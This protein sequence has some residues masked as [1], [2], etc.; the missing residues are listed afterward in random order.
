MHEASWAAHVSGRTRA[1][2][3]G[4]AA[5]GARPSSTAGFTAREGADGMW[6][7]VAGCVQGRR[8][9]R[10]ARRDLD[11]GPARAAHPPRHGAL[12]SAPRALLAPPSRR[13][14]PVPLAP[15]PSSR[16]P[17]APRRRA[18]LPVPE[19]SCAIRPLASS[20]GSAMPTTGAR[21]FRTA[22]PGDPARYPRRPAQASRPLPITGRTHPPGR[23]AGQQEDVWTDQG[24]GRRR[25]GR[26]AQDRHRRALRGPRYRGRRHCANGRWPW[27]S[28]SSSS[29]T[30]SPWTSRCRRWTASRRCARSAQRTAAAAADH[31]VQHADRARRHR[32]PRR[33]V[34]RRQRLRH[35]AGQRRQRRAVDGE[36]PRAAHPQDQGAHRPRRRSAGPDR[37]AAPRRPVAVRPRRPRAARR[38]GRPPSWSSAPRPAARR[39]W[40][41]CSRRCRPT[42]PVPVLLVQHMPPVFTRQF[43]Q[44]LDRL[45]ALRVVEAADGDPAAARHRAHRPRRPPPGRRPPA[46]RPGRPALNQAP[47][48]NFCRPAVDVL[49]RSAVAAYGGAV[50]GVV[51]TGMGSDGRA[52]PARSAPP[53]ARVSRRTRPP[54]WSG[55][56]PARS[57]RPG[58]ADEVLPLDRVAEAILRLLAAGD[59]R[60]VAAPRPRGGA[61]MTLTATELRL[62]AP[63]GAPRERDRAGSPARSTSSRRG[64][65]RS[66]G[67]CGLSGRQRVRRPGAQPARPGDH[68]ADRR[69]ADH[70][71]DLVVPRRRPVH[72]AH[73]DRAARSWSRPGRPDEQ[74]QIWSAACSS[75]QEPYSSRCCST[76]ALPGAATRVVDH[77]DRPVPRDGRAHPGRPVQPARGQPRPARPAA[78]AALHARRQRVGGRRR[79]CAGW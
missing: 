7:A 14:A 11:R 71:R 59:R 70:Q 19:K 47:P 53:A 57:P 16:S 5:G 28:W 23:P 76:D 61:A 26:R 12:A 15:S 13:C 54:P 42:L 44:R 22:R 33:A 67:S 3:D 37:R 74:L 60:A 49:F 68:P 45:C 79:R 55:A 69:G 36:R 24:D 77:R 34:R 75:G 41:R 63:A 2:A 27:P 65:C 21:H 48:E 35:Q 25:L 51:L 50:L 17:S 58:Y 64:C 20:T 8:D 66:P 31:H 43:A 52:A 18:V 1:L 78:G 10:P 62:R 56:C 29:P 39:R 4:A 72:R 32:D 73:R 9:G 30:W 6:N 46:A 38:P 40:P